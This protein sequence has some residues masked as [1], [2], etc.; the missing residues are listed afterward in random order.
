MPCNRKCS[1]GHAYGGLH[2]VTGSVGPGYGMRQQPS[3][4]PASYF[5]N[6]NSLSALEF[7]LQRQP[8][9]NRTEKD[10]APAK[11][12]EM[13]GAPLDG[14]KN[15]L[16]TARNTYLSALEQNLKYAESL[17]RN[18]IDYSLLSQAKQKYESL[19]AALNGQLSLVV[20]NPDDLAAPVQINLMGDLQ[21]NNDRQLSVGMPS[22][23]RKRIEEGETM[24]YETPELPLVTYESA[25]LFPGKNGW[26]Q[27]MQEDR[28]DVHQRRSKLEELI[29]REKEFL[30]N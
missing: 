19:R 13:Y 10:Y 6:P 12:R 5:A 4:A 11:F 21:L 7:E 22:Q 17:A 8:M 14:I 28:R 23:K 30:L 29:A 20:V 15:L 3:Y 9:Y 1:I 18:G 24:Y 26:E 25:V 16:D 2:L 27:D